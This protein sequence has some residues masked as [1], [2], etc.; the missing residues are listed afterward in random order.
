V[1]IAAGMAATGLIPVVYC[2]VNFL[3][4]RSLEQMRNDVVLQNRNVKFIATG[5]NDYFRF[6][7][8][9]HC[10]GADDIELMRLINMPVFDPYAAKRCNFPNLVRRWIT[11]ARCG[12]IRV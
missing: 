12:Y 1:G 11:D 5:V 6:L 9:S 3:V 7:G 2:I 8:A 4:Y 10:C